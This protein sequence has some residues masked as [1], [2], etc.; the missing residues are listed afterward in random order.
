MT[1][2]MVRVT[3]AICAKCGWRGGLGGHSGSYNGPSG[4]GVPQRFPLIVPASEPRS[5]IY[6]GTPE[7]PVH[8]PR[9]ECD[10]VAQAHIEMEPVE[11]T[12]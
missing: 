5:W 9:H 12:A 4:G 6:V 11:E 7:V 2:P 10:G 1:E 3:A 8:N